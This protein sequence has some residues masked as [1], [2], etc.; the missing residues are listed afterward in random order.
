MIQ[1]D[2][3]EVKR[4]KPGT[5]L[6]IGFVDVGLVGLIGTKYIVEELGM[7]MIG[8]IDV[9]SELAV[10][11]IK[12]GVAQF[13]LGIYYKHPWVVIVPEVPLPPHL[14]YPIAATI[15][16]Y[17]ERRGSKRIISITGLANF[18]RINVEPQI[19]WIVNDPELIE[20]MDK[21]KQIGKPL[22]D[23]VLYGPT[24]IILKTTKQRDFPSL[25]ILADAFPDFPDPGAT[26]KVLE[27]LNELYSLGVDTKKLLE[28]SEKI[29]AKLQTI[30][31]QA[32][33]VAKP[34]RPS[35]VM[36]T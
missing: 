2:V 31:S 18:N 19:R 29:K 35:M 26:A 27:A 11:P 8:G 6:L 10:S 16:D 23:G 22:R 36:Y 33:E 13:P 28:D 9:P 34:E 32:K 17:A 7:E 12:N 30:A 4:P 1:V 5:N 24:A 20:E 21:L 25:A 14:I 3:W 15:V